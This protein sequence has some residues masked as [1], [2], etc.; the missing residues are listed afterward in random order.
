MNDG[1]VCFFQD[2]GRKY[3]FTAGAEALPLLRGLLRVNERV[4]AIAKERVEAT[5]NVRGIMA[6]GEALY[7]DKPTMK[8]H[9]GAKGT[10]S[11]DEYAHPGLQSVYL[12]LK[13][14][15]RFT[16]SWA[17]LERAAESG[18]LEL[19]LSPMDD[20]MVVASLGGGPGYE[21]LACDWF[22]RYWRSTRNA[23]ADEKRAWLR[24]HDFLKSQAD[25][26]DDDVG[27]ASMD[28]VSLD[29]QPSWAPY[30][31][32]LGEDSLH[33]YSFAQWDVH[34]DESAVLATRRA[35]GAESIQLCLISNVMVY[36][37]DEATADVLTQLLAGGVRA[38][39]INERGADQ[40]I[41]GMVQRRGVVVLRLMRQEAGRDDRQLVFLPP[42]SDLLDSL[43]SVWHENGTA[44]KLSYATFPPKSPVFP[45]VPYEENKFL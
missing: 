25:D 39:L 45:N 37:S 8:Q 2:R 23:S 27:S 31:H 21:L 18:L 10:W 43:P 26:G 16:E 17:L 11:D 12:R 19:L 9:H 4:F 34:A 35:C 13:S 30:V 28:L 7:A 42:G 20:K 3:P 40:R 6:E 5:G 33:N 41:V 32:A 44:E 24:E 22:L 38:I 14:F 36:C 15:Q 29:L 1:S